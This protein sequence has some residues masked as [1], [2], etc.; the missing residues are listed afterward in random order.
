MSPSRSR[1]ASF[2]S[3]VV[4]DLWRHERIDRVAR[5]QLDEDEHEDA[6]PEQNRQG[7]KKP[8][9]DVTGHVVRSRR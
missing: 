5:R 8:A 3:G 2:A 1:I 9:E 4:I 6:H 7:M